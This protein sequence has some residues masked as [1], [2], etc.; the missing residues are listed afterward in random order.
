MPLARLTVAIRRA[1][2]TTRRRFA[3]IAI[4][5]LAFN[6][7]LVFLPVA[8]LLYLNTYERHLLEAQERAMAQQAR[9]A[10][11]VVATAPQLDRNSVQPLLAGVT[12]WGGTRLRVIDLTGAIVADSLLFGA[13]RQAEPSST[14][15]KLP[16]TRD[17]WLYR[18]GTGS[19]NVARAVY[20]RTLHEPFSESRREPVSWLTAPEVRAAMSGRYGAFTRVAVAGQRSVTLYSAVPVVRDGRVTGV[21]L[22]SQSTYRLLQALYDVRLR[23]FEAV[24]WS[25]AAAALLS[26]LLSATIVRP[27]RRLRADAA[28]VVARR[29]VISRRFRGAERPDEI[30]D[31]A[32]ALEDVTRRLEERLRF[33]E[34]FAADLSHEFKNPLAAIR[35]VAD[36]LGQIEDPLERARFLQMLGRDV[37]RLERL[38]AG[39]NDLVYLDVQLERQSA[40]WVAIGPLVRNLSDGHALRQQGR[41][42]IDVRANDNVLVRGTTDHLSQILDN[43]IDNATSFSPDG[44]R[45][46][47]A[48]KL[49]DSICELSVA[50]SGPG[51]PEAHL[52]RVFDRFFSYRPGKDASDRHH[53]GLGLA[54]VKAVVDAYGGTIELTN[55]EGGGACAT[56]RLPARTTASNVAPPRSE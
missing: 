31:L 27:L 2:A 9:L 22:V 56:L 36:T 49:E 25:V 35:T 47:I 44:G 45:V 16:R 5:L 7:L 52:Q 8:G 20:F 29:G 53:M 4:R 17:S 30:G 39:L 23:V 21:V 15:L 42:A 33:L 55:R 46:T 26:L 48:M 41:I 19:Y 43:L 28:A 6:L 14:Y 37:H 10:A 54:V 1:W 50:D 13:R 32:R 12:D 11:A 34:S 38:L 18:M 40:G 51:I 24:V 3:R